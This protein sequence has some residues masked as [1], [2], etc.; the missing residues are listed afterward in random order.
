MKKNIPTFFICAISLLFLWRCSGGGEEADAD[1]T[2]DTTPDVQPDETPSQGPPV[3]GGCRI[4]PADNPWN[5]PIDS[6]PVHENS[7]AYMQ[8]IGLSSTVHPDFG[9]VWEGAPIGIPYVVVPEDQAMVGV[10]F[11]YADESDPGPYPIPSDAPIEGG[12]DSSGDRHVLVIRE[13]ACILYELFAAYPQ[14]D[15]SWTAGS[16][17]IW[18]L[19]AS[20][21]RPAGWTSA[22]AAGLAILPGLVKYE[23]VYVDG[24]IRHAIRVT[25]SRTQDGY[26]SPASHAAGSCNYLSDCPPMGLR[27]RLKVDF[28]VS[29]FDPILQIILNAMKTYGLIVADNGSD[30]FISGAP[31]SRWDDDVLHNLHNVTAASF[32]AVYTGEI[33]EY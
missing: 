24:E 3:I 29:S 10:V 12:P 19:D 33:T 16:G 32:E 1:A 23:E 14:T 31:D 15:G 18:H 4:F 26:I 27:L 21:V 28:D 7:D 22:D 13:G 17:A 25:V 6:A 20:E 2:T 9:T 30:M 11:D 5:T 8:T